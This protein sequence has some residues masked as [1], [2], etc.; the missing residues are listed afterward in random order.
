VSND[1]SYNSIKC[2]IGFSFWKS[3]T[4]FLPISPQLQKLFI[5]FLKTSKSK[6]ASAVHCFPLKNFFACSDIRRS[7]LGLI[8]IIKLGRTVAYA[9]IE[10]LHVTSQANSE[11]KR[12]C[13]NQAGLLCYTQSSRYAM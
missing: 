2:L 7:A 5:V 9:I 8:K 6:Q 13:F 4:F 3:R 10:I 12:N 1:I 11:P